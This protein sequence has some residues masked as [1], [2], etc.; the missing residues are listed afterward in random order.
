MF[1]CR[2]CLSRTL[3]AIAGDAL[4]AR[5]IGRTRPPN[6]TPR[7][8]TPPI[9]RAAS[10]SAATK[11]T[12]V[13]QTSNGDDFGDGDSVDTADATAEKRLAR[14]GEKALR[15]ELQYLSDPLKLAEHVHYTLR[16]RKPEKALNL[17]RLASKERQVIV[18][19]NHCVDWYMTNNQPDEAIKIY[20]E[21]KKR[22]QFPD[23]YTYVLLLRGLARQGNHPA[24]GKRASVVKAMTIY[25]S[26][27]APNSRVKPSIYHTNAALRVCSE[28]LDMDA[29]WTVAARL[30]SHGHGA[31][32]HMTYCILLN[33]IRH[34]AFGDTPIGATL[35]QISGRRQEAVN[36]GR[37]I[38]QEV[39]KKWRAGEVHIDEELV[40]AMGRLLLISKRAQDWDD[41]FNLV[42]QTMKIERQIAP[43]GSKT[44][45]LEHVPQEHD[46]STEEPEPA[47]DAEGYQDAPSVKA[48]NPVA[49]L[50]P[51]TS[52]G[53][54]ASSLAYVTPGNPTLSMLISAC[55]ELRTPKTANAYW[56]LLT[57]VDGP[58]QLEVDRDN[59]HALLRLLGKSRSSAKAIEILKSMPDNGVKPLNS[60]FRIAMSTCMRDKNNHNALQHARA[61]VDEMEKQYAN[62][63]MH[64][65]TQY[66]NLALN[67]SDGPKIVSALDRLNPIVEKLRSKISGGRHK[68]RSAQADIRDKGETM[69]LF[70]AM[71]GAIDTLLHRGFVP[72]EDLGRWRG[73]RAALTKLI[74]LMKGKLGEQVTNIEEQREAQAVA[75][76]KRAARRENGLNLSKT[77]FALRKARWQEQKAKRQEIVRQR[78]I[79]SRREHGQ[80]PVEGLRDWKV[81]QARSDEK[82]FADSPMDLA[83]SG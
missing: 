41:L 55:T 72:S 43:I 25:N 46:Y 32:D 61:V 19:W 15:T 54:K 50:P 49:P 17:C 6:L 23:S 81:Q 47:E 71:V 11:N 22:A 21:M 33:A 1:E 40:C 51:D 76:E 63:D 82:A 44:R 48:F 70:Q 42:H 62:P 39:I 83:M 14:K 67:T 16:C 78:A 26:M 64:T 34:G 27:M 52:K 4:N 74:G 60:T 12:S 13:L 79:E 77:E 8:T 7:R 2:A 31:P 38:W 57:K 36:Q 59:F 53:K 65:L 80:R 45:H 75:K 68:P 35:D 24:M 58:Y 18:S 37:R 20:N 10:T 56:S 5:S 30:P 28:A 3:R 66:L 69:D 9:R 29:L 73:Q